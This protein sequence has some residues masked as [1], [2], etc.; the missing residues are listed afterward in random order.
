MNRCKSGT[1]TISVTAG[2]AMRSETRRSMSVVAEI[3]RSA[4]WTQTW[5]M[6]GCTSRIDDDGSQHGTAA[7]REK[8]VCSMQ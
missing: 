4:A 5:F 8:G 7:G 3:P 2:V 6:G 1:E